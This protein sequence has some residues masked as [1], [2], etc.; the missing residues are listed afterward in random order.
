MHPAAVHADAPDLH[1]T[2]AGPA[3]RSAVHAVHAEGLFGH[4]ENHCIYLYCV[5]P[6]AETACIADGPCW[7]GVGGC[8]P[9]RMMP[10]PAR[11]AL[12]GRCAPE[13]DNRCPRPRRSARYT[14]CPSQSRERRPWDAASHDLPGLRGQSPATGET[15]LRLSDAIR[16]TRRY[17]TAMLPDPRGGGPRKS[18]ESDRST[19]PPD[20]C[21]DG[22]AIERFLFGIE[23][24]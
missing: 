12:L 8:Q 1:A 14:D 6:S 11:A 21:L 9:G 3:G 20:A 4:K 24:A 10:R 18:T 16:S 2:N 22:C 17:R 19:T 7:R 15:A 5:D 13:A 23:Q